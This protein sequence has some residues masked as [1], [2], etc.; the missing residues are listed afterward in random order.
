MVPSEI[1]PA[2][3]RDV[4]RVFTYG[5]LRV[6]ESN[7]GEFLAGRFDRVFPARLPGYATRVAWHGYLVACPQKGGVLTGELFELSPDRSAETLDRLD[8]L[9]G[10]SPGS[11]QGT[12]YER[13]LCQVWTEAGPRPAWVYTAPQERPRHS[14]HE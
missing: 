8:Q 3:H 4:V 12:D 7:H 2:G 6:G 14:P 13:Q 9:E 1:D 11:L 10:L 5:S